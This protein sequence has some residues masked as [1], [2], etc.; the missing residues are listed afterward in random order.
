VK[1]QIKT[2]P[3]I[4][5][6]IHRT[7]ESFA[8]FSMARLSIRLLM[9]NRFW[10]RKLDARRLCEEI[11]VAAEP[12]EPQVGRSS[13]VDQQKVW[14]YMTFTAAGEAS[15]KRMVAEFRRQRLA[16]QQVCDHNG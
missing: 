12:D 7:A 11:G 1:I 5:T 10:R 3:A 15:F 9:G 6:S 2:L 8:H 14:L 13:H 16:L 4:G